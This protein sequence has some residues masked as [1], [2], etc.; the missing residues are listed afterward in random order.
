MPE[1]INR[2]LMDSI[3]DFLFCTERSGVV[4]LIR[5]G[6]PKEKIFLVGNV[7][8]DTLLRNRAK[9]EKSNILNQLNLNG[10]GF[11]FLTLHRSSNSVFG[12]GLKN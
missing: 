12:F 5:E 8:I 9:A 10:N 4:N 11:A 7:M 3:S 2:L 6:I 1:E